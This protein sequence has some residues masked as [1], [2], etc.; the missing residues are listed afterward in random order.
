[1]VG[2]GRALG[3][4]G[5]MRRVVGLRVRVVV[6]ILRVKRW[7]MFDALQCRHLRS[8]GGM[9][10]CIHF[11]ERRYPTNARISIEGELEELKFTISLP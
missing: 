5:G 6:W 11:Q 10:Y 3:V 4:R 9:P 7:G 8:G 2:L 1:M